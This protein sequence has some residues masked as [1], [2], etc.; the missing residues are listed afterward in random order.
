MRSIIGFDDILTVIVLY[1]KE[2]CE[3]ESF[4]SLKKSVFYNLEGKLDLYI[5]DNSP[6]SHQVN[7]NDYYNII[8]VHDPSNPGVSKAYNM[9]CKMAE[10][11]NKQWILIFDQDTRIPCNALEVY[12]NAI[13]AIDSDI[14]II[15]PKLF[16]GKRMISPC[17]YILHRGFYLSKIPAS[18]KFEIKGHSFLNSG[19]LLRVSSIRNI[20]YFD[21]Q[22]FDYSDHDLIYRFGEK[23]K[24]ANIINLELD[25]DLSSLTG[26]FEI[27]TEQTIKRVAMFRKASLRM[28]KKYH[29]PFPIFWLFLRSIKLFF[30]TKKCDYIKIALIGDSYD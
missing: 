10:S 13:F 30:L 5:Y 17:K 29:S 14:D 12:Y 21:E 22:L 19:L 1:K 28:S 16:T 25:H 7:S 15:S 23:R 6:E 24:F 3:S 27:N 8:Y 18:G 11:L 9:A 20:G 4:K 2:L 26:N